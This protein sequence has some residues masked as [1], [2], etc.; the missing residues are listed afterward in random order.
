MDTAF[1]FQ[2]GQ[3]MFDC[4]THGQTPQDIHGFMHRH[5]PIPILV[6]NFWL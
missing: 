3:K 1:T 6:L 5:A 2:C 4:A